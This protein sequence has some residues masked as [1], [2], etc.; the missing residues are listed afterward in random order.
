MVA[1]MTALSACLATAAPPSGDPGPAALPPRVRQIVLHVLGHPSY[2]SP[3]RR[4]IFYPPMRTQA[5][6]KQRF[7]A[8]WIVWTDGSVWPRHAAP[9]EL[10]FWTPDPSRPADAALRRRLA[11]EAAPVYS[12]VHPGNRSSVGIELAH[13]GRGQDPFPPAQVASVAFLVRTLLEMSGGRLGLDAVVG[14]KDVDQRPAY[15]RTGCQRPGCPVFVDP[16]G[17][18]YRRRVDP[19]ESLFQALALEGLAVPRPGGSDVDLRRA[20]ALLPP[21]QAAGI[22]H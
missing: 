1:A 15:T 5:L 7:G 19:P 22:G 10:P 6:W 17:Q 21:G 16:A 14:H 2:A 12:H 11:A 9:G 3:E 8:H 13:S 20:E 18:P 4:F